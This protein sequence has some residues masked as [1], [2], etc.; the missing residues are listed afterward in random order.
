VFI[1]PGVFITDHGQNL[2]PGT[3]IAEQ[4]SRAAAVSIGDDVWVGA[5]AVI[6]PGVAIG[7][8]SVVGAGAVVREDVPEG[9]VVAGEPARVIR[10]R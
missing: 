3:R 10:H 8:G 5:G 9:T 1:A 4:G 6:L 7:Y 2:V